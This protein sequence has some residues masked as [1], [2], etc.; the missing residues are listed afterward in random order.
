MKKNTI[1]VVIGAIAIAGGTAWYLSKGADHAASAAPKGKGGQQGPTVVNVVAPQVRDVPIVQASNGTV[2]PVSTVDLHPQTTATIRKVHIKEGDFVK[3]GQLMF[4]LDDRTD[5]ANVDKA[6]A[7]VAKDEATLADLERQYQRAR[8]LFAQHFIAQSQVDSLKSQVDSARAVLKADSAAAQSSRVSASFTS[9]RSP[10]SGRVG[11][12]NVYAGSLVQPATSLTTITQLDPITVAFTLP[13][14]ALADLL[15]AQRAG[16]VPV[17][18]SV[19][20]AKPVLGQ[21]SFVDNAVDPVAGTIKVKAQFDN[22]G[23]RLWPGQYV[24]AKV[25]VQTLKNAVVIPQ[26]AVVTSARGTFVYAMQPDQTAA[27]VPVRKLYAFGQEAAVAGLKGD[28]KV[29]TEGK[30]NLRP[31][32]KVR[33]AGT[34]GG[35]GGG[36]A[37]ASTGGPAQ[38]KGAA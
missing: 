34:G 4:T 29:I 22:A 6:Q 31:G 9:I 36:S 14:S 28:E 37:A 25:T 1:G 20:D 17:E 26:S 10:M 13:E 12:I 24:N 2:T 23:A 32:A 16:R 27:Q 3:A 21:L 19:G 7:Q 38:S 8:D 35:A 15:A 33:V 11:G 5:Q 30:Q 18:A